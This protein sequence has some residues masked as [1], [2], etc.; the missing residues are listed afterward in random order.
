M[1][2]DIFWTVTPERLRQLADRME[3]CMKHAKVGESR[4]IAIE[5][6]DAPPYVDLNLK[7]QFPPE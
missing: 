4:T 3:D 2:I 6:L 7:I 1:N 5:P